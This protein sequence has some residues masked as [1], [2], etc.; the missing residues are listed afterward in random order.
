M[1]KDVKKPDYY[2][3]MQVISISLIWILVAGITWWVI[4]LIV[5]SIELHDAPD[6]SVIISIVVIPIFIAI[7]STLTYVFVGLQR[8]KVEKNQNRG[9]KN[10]ANE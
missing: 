8:N 2:F 3:I 5:L 10:E 4:R 9:D 1:T 7:A 6:L